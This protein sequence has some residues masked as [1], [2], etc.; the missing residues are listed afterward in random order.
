[1]DQNSSDLQKMIYAYVQGE[2]SEEQIMYLWEECVKD[3][4]LLEQLEIQTALKSLLG[5]GHGPL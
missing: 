1:M 3:P 5:G 4:A 2:L